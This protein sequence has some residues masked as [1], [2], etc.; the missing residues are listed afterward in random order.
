MF[1]RAP[2]Q[3]SFQGNPAETQQ[4]RGQTHGSPYASRL[5]VS[6][7]PPKEDLRRCLALA[8]PLLSLGAR[9]VWRAAAH[10]ERNP[11]RARIVEH[12]GEYPRARTFRPGCRPGRQ[13]IL[14]IVGAPYSPW[15]PTRKR[16]DVVCRSPAATPVPW[17][18]TSPRNTWRIRSSRTLRPSPP[19]ARESELTRT[20]ESS[21]WRGV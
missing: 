20:T 1:S 3:P 11:S 18:A 10:V 19:A 4:P 21:L 5:R 8:V 15:D 9:H 16:S 13:S 12:P 6:L 14:R 17:A 7:Q 2:T